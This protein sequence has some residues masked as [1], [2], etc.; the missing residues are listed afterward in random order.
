MILKEAIN[1]AIKHSGASRVDVAMTHDLVMLHV[2]VQDY[3]HGFNVDNANKGYGLS[4]MRERA[5]ESGAAFEIRSAAGS[6][7]TIYI[8]WPL[9]KYAS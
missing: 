3:G 4:T 5:E 2:V 8:K 6:A 7:T 1:N 9:R